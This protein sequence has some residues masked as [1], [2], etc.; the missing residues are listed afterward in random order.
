MYKKKPKRADNKLK[1]VQ[2]NV[3]ASHFFKKLKKKIK[4]K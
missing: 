1:H 2:L 3:N 4:L